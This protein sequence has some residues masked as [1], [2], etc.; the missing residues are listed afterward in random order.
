MHCKEHM[1]YTK[2][3]PLRELVEKHG[4]DLGL[5]YNGADLGLGYNGADLG[6]GYNGADLGSGYNGAD[7]GLG[8]K[9]MLSFLSC[10]LDYYIA[11][12]CYSDQFI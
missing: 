8:C 10:L 2:M 9:S 12:T 6:L 7:L 4:A 5:G 1:A 11:N 3:S